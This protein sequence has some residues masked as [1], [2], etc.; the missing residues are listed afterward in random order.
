MV[1]EPSTLDLIWRTSFQASPILVQPMM[2][3]MLFSSHPDEESSSNSYGDFML[4]VSRPR[5]MQSAPSKDCTIQVDQR[6]PRM[7][8]RALDQSERRPPSER[9]QMFMRPKHE[10][11]TP[12]TAGERPWYCVK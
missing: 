9:M 2:H 7:P 11:K 12:E 8:Y 6:R 1:K 3:L 10:A 4:V 5:T